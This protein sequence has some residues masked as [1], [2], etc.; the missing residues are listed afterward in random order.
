MILNPKLLEAADVFS[1]AISYLRQDNKG[2]SLERVPD[3]VSVLFAKL[4]CGKSRHKVI[5]NRKR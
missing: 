5:K 4:T 1:K 2:V 3:I